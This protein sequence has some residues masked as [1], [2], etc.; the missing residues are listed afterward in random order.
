[1]Q[2]CEISTV[3][4]CVHPLVMQRI[5]GRTKGRDMPAIIAEITAFAEHV[6]RFVLTGIKMHRIKGSMP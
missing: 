4:M 3:S 1:M 5:A 2:F 6:V